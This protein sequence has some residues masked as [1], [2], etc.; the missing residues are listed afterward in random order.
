MRIA[1]VASSG[2]SVFAQLREILAA[3]DAAAHQYLVVTDRPCGIETLCQKMGVACHRIDERDNVEFSRRAADWL[4]EQGG[5]DFVLLFFLRLVTGELFGRFPTFN[6]HPSLLPA[7]RGFNPL[8]QA[9]AV[10]ARF[11]GATLHLVNTHADAGAIVAQVCMPL[12]GNE[13]AERLEKISFIQKVYL[14]LVLVDLLQRGAL[15]VS[16]DRNDAHVEPGLR[17]TDRCN[18]RLSDERLHQAVLRLQQQEQVEVI[19]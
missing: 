10:R 6:I 16:A 18:P 7:F 12:A 4:S 14:A 8:A 17:A 19:Q 11:M 15:S 5:A 2:G 3:R 13:K 1:V 9:L